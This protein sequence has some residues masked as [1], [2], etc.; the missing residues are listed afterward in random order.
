M[1]GQQALTGEVDRIETPGQQKFARV[2]YGGFDFDETIDDFV[3]SGATGPTIALRIGSI[4]EADIGHPPSAARHHMRMS[5]N[6]TWNDYLVGESFIHNRRAPRLKFLDRAH[7]KHSTFPHG[8]CRSKWRATVHG[9]DSLGGVNHGV[10]HWADGSP[11]GRKRR[12]VPVSAADPRASDILKGMTDIL[13]RDVPDEVVASL[14]AKARNNG[15][16]RAEYLRRL[17]ADQQEPALT[18]EQLNRFAERTADLSNPDVM[19]AAWR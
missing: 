18:R 13:I 5:L 7:G 16:T 4:K 3:D 8:D 15:Q 12:T 6:E 10:V 17:L 11:H 14:D 2:L 1:L 19:A 9:E